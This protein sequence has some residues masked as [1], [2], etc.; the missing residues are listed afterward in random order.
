V[1]KK[2]DPEIERSNASHKRFIDVLTEAFAAL[3]GEVWIE[4]QKATTE[5]LDGEDLEEIVF[6][7]TF[8]SLDLDETNDGEE[9]NNAN[10]DPEG[11][12]TNDPINHQK[13]KTT[14]KG[15]NRK[16]G[17]KDKG[18]PKPAAKE[19]SL[20]EVPLESYRII[21]DESGLV[22]DYLMAV[23][24]LVREWIELRHYLQGLW[25]EVSYGSLNSAIAG[26]VSNV[27]I[28]MVKKTQSLIFVEFPGHD[29]YET[30]MK[31]ITRGNVEKAQGMF[32][33][34]IHRVGPDNKTIE[35]VHEMDVDVKEQFLIHTYQALLDFVTDFQQTRSGKPTKRVLSE[36]R[37]WDPN[38]DLQ[39][40]SREQ[41]IK[42][43]RAYT[44]NWLYD[45]VNIFSSIVVQRNTMK[46]QNIVLET[47][48]W[49]TS[50][51]WDKHRRL[52]GLNDV[53][54][55]DS[56]CYLSPLKSFLAF[57]TFYTFNSLCYS[58]IFSI[59]LMYSTMGKMLTPLLSTVCW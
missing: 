14:G 22:T 8:S 45:L 28:A 9:E 46:R 54:L 39:R 24:S 2:P 44:I 36:I 58:P 35:K 7:N 47:V 20:D 5:A 43:R 18:K 3:G 51:P 16:R 19:P 17:R 6:R 59:L 40:A 13:K 4:T 42:W 1:S 31:T 56:T 33:V 30:V 53:R 38:F 41:R 57:E 25:R 50:G 21:E 52:F 27:A 10:E 26:E 23:Y 48:D 29:S 12:S 34:A 37:N 15:K 11:P 32:H 55:L 49:S